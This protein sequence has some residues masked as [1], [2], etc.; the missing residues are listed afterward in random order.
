MGI[1]SSIEEVFNLRAPAGR[2][3]DRRLHE[4]VGESQG[5][6][7]VG[8]VILDEIPMGIDALYQNILGKILTSHLAHMFQHVGKI[9]FPLLVGIDQAGGNRY[10]QKHI[11]RSFE[12]QLR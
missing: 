5:C 12:M 6:S 2:P 11:F 8:M 7:L 3:E 1:L 10:Q 4:R 9:C